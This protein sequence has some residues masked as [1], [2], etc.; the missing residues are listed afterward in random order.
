MG[1]Y[2]NL[3]DILPDSTK[4]KFRDAWRTY[5]F[6]RGDTENHFLMYYS[7]LY[8]A[9]QTWQGLDGSQWFNGKSSDENFAESRAWLNH[10]INETVRYGQIEFDSPRYMYYYLTPF[11]L[12]SQFAKDGEMRGRAKMMLDYLF[13]D[14]AADYLHG[15]YCGAHSRD[16]E[17]SSL[18]P[19]TAEVMS[20]A[21]LYFGDIDIVK[22]M[23]DVAFA[24]LTSYRLPYI[25][26]DIA[27]KKAHM[28]V[29]TEQKRA[30]NHIRY[31]GE[32][33]PVVYKYDCMT[34][35]FCLGS[36]QGGIVQPIQQRS[37]ALTFNSEKPMNQIF[38]L[39][40]TY[41]ARELATYFPEEPALMVGDIGKAKA[42]YTSDDKWIG[43]SDYEQIAQE[44][45]VLLAVYNIPA[46]DPVGHIDIFLPKSLDTIEKDPSG[47]IFIREGNSFAAIYMLRSY[48]WIDENDYIRLRSNER[49]NGYIVVASSTTLRRNIKTFA[50]F[51]AQIFHSKIDTTNFAGGGDVSYS[52]GFAVVG[53]HH[54]KRTKPIEDRG[55][56][57]DSEFG[58]LRR[59]PDIAP[60]MSSATGSGILKIDDDNQIFTLDF[61]KEHATE[62]L[63]EPGQ[64]NGG[65]E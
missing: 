2:L 40:P 57:S 33:N 15:S 39:H 36:M 49:K 55:L 1:C 11:F 26:R 18:M 38:G 65:G 51:K 60:H 34:P 56:F 31:G 50:Q 48:Q 47:W 30:R 37:W 59:S 20:Y 43:G 22:P 61:S 64:E 3:Q 8:L 5:T 62:T 25:I 23:P 42:G 21:G 29:H 45:N 17:S 54:W 27:L 63:I 53:F 9:S 13:A 24:A 12:L 6:Y 16:A 4:K 44:K 52:R 32:K 28:I 35:D 7:G 41:S 46:N 10:W 19:R 58:D 14:F